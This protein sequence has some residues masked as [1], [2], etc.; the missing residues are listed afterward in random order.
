MNPVPL[1][2]IGGVGGSGTRLVAQMLGAAGFHLGDDLNDASDTLWFTLLFKRVDILHVDG[3]QFDRLTRLL[4]AALHRDRPID[5]T[6]RALVRS[7]A[8]DD[9]PQ[10][11]S[12]WLRARA[13]SLLAAVERPPVDAPL[14]WKEPNTHVVIQ[15][16]WQ[17]LP[18]LRY[19]H[20]VRNGVMMAHSSNQNQLRL[21][22]PSVLGQDG[23]VTP[24]RSLAYWC[25]VH[26]RMQ[27]TLAD[28]R[29]RMYWLDYDRLCREPQAEAEKLCRFLD[30]GVEQMAPVLSH[31]RAP[32][33]RTGIDLSDFAPADL[34]HVCSLGYT[35]G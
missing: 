21:W 27:R 8:D 22:G 10:H 25:R 4:V 26:Q 23:P 16:L 12:G 17:R 20:V 2:A 32:T 1:V 33:Q 9:R 13:E 6:D 29:E 28:N 30:C 35:L 14:A 34:E 24:A 7:L 5:A 3:P 15:R 11:S 19:V 31:V 18:Q